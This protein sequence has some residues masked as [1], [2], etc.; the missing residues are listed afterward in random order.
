MTLTPRA[1]P[2]PVPLPRVWGVR[3]TEIT[4]LLVANGVFI[5]LMWIRHGGPDLIGTPGGSSRPRGS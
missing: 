5:V 2:R 4:A 1:R 3:A